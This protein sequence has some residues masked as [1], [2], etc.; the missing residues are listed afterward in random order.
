MIIGLDVRSLFDKPTGVGRFVA[1]LLAGL[2]ALDGHNEY[3]LYGD[4]RVDG[5]LVE[6]RALR[7][8][9]VALPFLPSSFGWMHVRLL[10]ALLR[11]PVDVFHF[12]FHTIPLIR[13]WKTVVS[14][15]DITYEVHPEW[16]PVRGVLGMRLL[17]RYAARRADRILTCSHATRRDIVRYYGVPEERVRVTYYGVDRRFMRIEDS[18]AIQKVRAAYARPGEKMILYVGSIHRRRNI[19][20]LLRA[21]RQVRERIGDGRLVL[22]GKV[23]YVGQ[24]LGALARDLG[25]EGHVVFADYIRDEDLVL[26]YNAADLFIFPSSYEGFGLPVLEA[27]ACGT[28]VITAGNSSLAEIAGEAAILID[29]HDI[30]EM[31]EAMC[32]ILTDGRLRDELRVKGLAQASTFSWERTTRET[33][34]AYEEVAAG[35]RMAHPVQAAPDGSRRRPGGACG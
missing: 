6:S 10:P 24:D 23:E 5:R 1:N 30:D 17:S 33:L 12:P 4:R 15:N 31:A 25:I 19:D 26:L 29:P 3:R 27:M 32:D 34:Q 28:P 21:F 18:P 9:Y 11:H 14:I 2:S 20:R 22:V 8:R 16:Y 7:H 13:N 35:R